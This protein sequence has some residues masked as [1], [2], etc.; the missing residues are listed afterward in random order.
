MNN[1]SL[2]PRLL[3]THLQEALADT[4]VVLITGPR[5]A[6]KTTLVRQLAGTGMRYLTLDDN[7]TLLAA[8]QDPVG[9]IRTLDRA[10]I[11]EIQRAPQLLLAIKKTVDEDRRPGRFLLTGS[12]NLMTLPLVADSLAGRM[13][14]L[15]LYPFAQVETHYQ[16][17]CWLDA[18]FAGNIPVTTQ[19]LLGDDLIE[20]VLRG[21]YPEALTRPNP[22]R[23]QTWHR[24]Y[25][26][27]LIQRD[28]Q[29]IATIDKLGQLPLFLNA[30]AEMAGQL[31]NYSQLGAQTGMDAK[32]ANKYMG[33]FEQMYVLKR[34]PV[35]ANNRLKR[36]LKSPKLQFIDSGLLASVR[37]LTVDTLKRDRTLFGALLETF[38]YAELLKHSTWAQADYQI[39]YYRDTD[40]YE[41]D[42]VVK[43][44]AGELIG[45]EVKASATLT[46][47][48]LRGLK[49][50]AGLAGDAMKLGVI[51]YDGTEALPLGEK[52]MAV[53]L[54]SLWGS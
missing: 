45:V 43:N 26:D 17:S 48:D 31:C 35:W 10:V 24:Q 51:L 28:V 42:F 23:R 39:L 6:G 16:T 50:L 34:I 41:V 27:A 12:A 13:E 4:P 21:G 49:R 11:D 1:A 32:T 14:T 15:P 44:R 53:P 47:K 5:Q 38:V 37:G 40:Q 25:L 20:A 30:L 22:R 7:L 3:L 2:Y 18:I 33:I 54:S 8:Q 52:L 9:F 36:V 19:P 29:D 46:E